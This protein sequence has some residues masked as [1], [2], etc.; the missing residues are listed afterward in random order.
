MEGDQL[1]G[2]VKSQLSRESL[3]SGVEGCQRSRLVAAGCEGADEQEVRRLPQGLPGHRELGERDRLRGIAGGQGCL[4]SPL[5]SLEVRPGQPGSILLRPVVV[6]VLRQRVAAPDLESRLEP[7]QGCDRLTF[8]EGA[9]TG[10]D[11][12]Q[13]R[14]GI[15]AAA[16]PGSKGVAP[17]TREDQG[18]IAER[19]ASPV[20]QDVQIGTRVGGCPLGPQRLAQHVPRDVLAPAGQQDS[21]DPPAEPSAERARRDLLGVSKSREAPEQPDLDRHGPPGPYWATATKLQSGRL[22]DRK[23]ARVVS[24]RR[25]STRRWQ[26]SAEHGSS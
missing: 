20:D 12:G 5:Q 22:P 21:D 13:E 2:E 26:W 4:G 17:G 14:L 24:L 9:V 11:L 7:P 19:F 1:R 18:G 15:D 8:V 3:A 23:P 6:G 10:D 25:H 16:I